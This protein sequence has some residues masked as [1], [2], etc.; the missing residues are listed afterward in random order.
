MKPLTA[1]L[2]A[3]LALL[4]LAPGALRAETVNYSYSWSA[5][6]STVINPPGATG[7]VLF[8]LTPDGSTSS[9]LND[10]SPTVLPAA[11]AQTTSSAG[12]NSPDKFDVAYSLKL[13][14]TEGANS[15]DLTFSGHITGNLTG[16]SSTLVATFDSPVTR[17]LALGTHL[18]TVTI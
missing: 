5:L 15:G 1:R 7:S 17:T 18:F 6:P 8:A 14:L 2:P 9:T 10:P 16:V 12:A 4:L 3:L 11:N 13:H